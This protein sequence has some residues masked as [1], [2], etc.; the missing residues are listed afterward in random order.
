MTPSFGIDFGTTNTRVA[1][2]DGKTVQLAAFSGR[3]GEQVYQLPTAIAYRDG[4]PVASGHAAFTATPAVRFPVPLKW[5]LTS[6]EVIDLGDGQTKEPTDAVADFL[7]NL[8][9]AV[10]KSFPKA[11][12]ETAAVT[13]PVHFPPAARGRL[14]AAFRQAGIEVTH[15]FFEPIAAIYAGLVGQP[16][17]GVSAVF[18]WGGGSLDVAAVEVRDG[19][20]RTREVDGWHR[21]GTH[22]DRM[23]AE[24]AVNGFLHRHADDPMLGTLTAE[25]VLDRSRWGRSALDQ[26]VRAKEVLKDRETGEVTVLDF[27]NHGALEYELTRPTFAD[28]IRTD[29]TGG[30]ARLARVLASSGVTPRTLSRLFL[31]GGTCNVREVRE[32]LGEEYAAKLTATLRLPARL[33][34][35]NASGGLDD[36]GNATAIGAALLAGQGAAAT[37]AASV[38]VRLAGAESEARFLPVFRQGDP[39]RFD[40]SEEVRLF[41][42]NTSGGVARL[43]VCEQTDD[44]TQ[45]SGR[46]LKV[47]TVPVDRKESWLR[48]GFRVDR[49]LTLQVRAVGVKNFQNDPNKPVP[50]ARVTDD[51]VQSLKLGFQLPAA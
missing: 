8:R 6:E 49:H 3:Q 9:Q 39:V 30:I 38:G 18:D 29:L 27:L 26:A 43:L 40:Q 32:R 4:H 14:H 1:H 46:L 21:G 36:I 41:L 19:I 22:F 28:L 13:I 5:S 12:L 17:T 16:T 10:V 31:S 15:F 7:R 37:F 51:W 50:P 33:V 48:V 2:F 20:A 23:I 25:Q 35:R 24:Q 11:P 42:T 47:I 44:V 45:P 34:P